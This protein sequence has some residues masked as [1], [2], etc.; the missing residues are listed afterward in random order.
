MER[1][2]GRRHPPSA[3]DG[4][5]A[6]GPGDERGQAHRHSAHLPRL[7][8]ATARAVQVRSR[9][10]PAVEGRCDSVGD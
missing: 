6:P 9:V 4:R 3:G 10:E 1:E 2:R 7:V 5:D 8:A